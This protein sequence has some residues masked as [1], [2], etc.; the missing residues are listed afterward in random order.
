[1]S[2][3]DEKTKKKPEWKADL[4]ITMVIERNLSI[5][6]LKLKPKKEEK[7]GN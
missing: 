1:M 3:K 4:S 2:K 5:S 6:K 7:M